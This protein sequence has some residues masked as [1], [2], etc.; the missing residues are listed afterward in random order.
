MAEDDMII[1]S[2]CV[3]YFGSGT[4]LIC[5]PVFHGEL[6]GISPVSHFIG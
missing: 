5:G 4:L 6:R 1:E 3:Y 2:M